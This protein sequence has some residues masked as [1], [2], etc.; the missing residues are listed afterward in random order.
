MD[1][2]LSEM[3]ECSAV[4]VAIESHSYVSVMEV[5]RTFSRTQEEERI[6]QGQDSPNLTTFHEKYPAFY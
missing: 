5:C 1:S 4:S 6:A 2:G 3:D